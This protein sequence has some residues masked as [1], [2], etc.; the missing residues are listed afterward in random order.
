MSVI[1]AGAYSKYL[2][3]ELILL[4]LQSLEFFLLVLHIEFVKLI[5]YFNPRGTTG[6]SEKFNSSLI[7]FSVKDMHQDIEISLYCS[8]NT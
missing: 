2:A 1:H 7:N 5:H 6:S 4:K 3:V 8:V